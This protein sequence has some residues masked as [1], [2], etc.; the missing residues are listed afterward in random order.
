MESEFEESI[1]TINLMA[2]EINRG[3]I[4]MKSAKDRLIKANLAARGF[5]REK[6]YQPGAPFL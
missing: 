2:K 4:M 3:R 6:I 1:E 5:N